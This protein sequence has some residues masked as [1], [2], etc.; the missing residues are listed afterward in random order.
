MS[1]LTGAGAARETNRA[2]TQE[3]AQAAASSLNKTLATQNKDNKE[4]LA[5]EEDNSV[6][7]IVIKSQKL[8]KKKETRPDKVKSSKESV[9]VRKDDAG[10]LG[11]GF[12]ERHGNRE[13]RLNPNQLGELAEDLGNGFHE[14]STADQMIALVRTT[15]TTAGQP[16]DVA[17]VD[18]AFEFLVEVT[19]IETEKAVGNAKVRLE[20]IGERIETAKLKHFATYAAEIQVAQKIIGA[21]DA[22]VETTGQTVK[23]TL[24]HYRDVVHNPPDLQALR[25][26]YEGKGYKAMVL[27]LKGLSNYLGGNFKR[28]NLESPELGQLASA[29]RKMQALIGVFRQAKTQHATMI[30]Y[31]AAN[32]L[33]T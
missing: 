13:Y 15:M 11:E 5:E 24:N 8:E 31:L 26:F 20:K 10:G 28:S 19:K 16:P 9:L 21:V 22:V 6:P 25:K 1:D 3:S 18:K 33:L 14:N 2:Q 30:N 4:S 23:E 12:S 32:K 29:A 7:A 27:E 17:I